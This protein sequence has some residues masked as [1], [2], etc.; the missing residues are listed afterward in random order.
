M[1][2]KKQD[3]PEMQLAN[4]SLAIQACESTIESYRQAISEKERLIEEKAEEIARLQKLTGPLKVE[5]LNESASSEA[6]LTEEWVAS[7]ST[8]RVDDCYY[9]G[10]RLYIDMFNIPFAHMLDGSNN[11]CLRELETESDL[12]ALIRGLGYEICGITPG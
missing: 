6:P 8:K 5:L 3:T 7:L 12:V 4:L 10:D 11:V 9:L 1:A 2:K